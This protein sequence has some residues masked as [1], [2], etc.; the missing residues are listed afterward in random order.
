MHVP[1]CGILS[2]DFAGPMREHDARREFLTVSQ[3]A[4]RLHWSVHTIRR[5]LV[6]LRTWK[7]D[8]GGIPCVRLGAREYVP[9]W[10]LVEML[11]EL[12]RP[13]PTPKT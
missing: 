1:E 6:P 9:R 8:R 13:P 11:D 10:W 2:A 7:R 4:R 5:H 3:V 12:T